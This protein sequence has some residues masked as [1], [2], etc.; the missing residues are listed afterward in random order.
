[1]DLHL[2]ISVKTSC[3]RNNTESDITHQTNKL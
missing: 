2:D 1:M 3:T